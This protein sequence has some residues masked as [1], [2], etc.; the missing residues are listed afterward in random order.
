MFLVILM[1]WMKEYSSP[2]SACFQTLA[3]AL[4]RHR[5]KRLLCFPWPAALVGK[6]LC[7]SMSYSSKS[8]RL[9]FEGVFFLYFSFSLSLCLHLSFCWSCHVLITLCEPLKS[10]KCLGSL[11]LFQN[12]K[13]V[14]EWFSQSVTLSRIEPCSDC[15]KN[16]EDFVDFFLE[17]VTTPSM[18]GF[19][20]AFPLGK[21]RI[22]DL[23]E[24]VVWAATYIYFSI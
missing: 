22:V 13:W 8:Q 15:A 18:S 11:Y 3:I 16:G 2:F 7:T 6:W 12:K 4:F 10:H 14:T 24:G 19:F 21:R 20:W 9:L 1:W 17:T 23:A 5:G